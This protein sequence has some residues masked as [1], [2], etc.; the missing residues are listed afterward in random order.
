MSDA[1]APIEPKP[2]LGVGD[3]LSQTFQQYFSSFGFYFAIVFVPYLLAGLFSAYL[4]NVA[5]TGSID[6]LFSFLYFAAVLVPVIAYVGIQGVIVRAAISDRL[7]QG[8]QLQTAV[9]IAIRNILP[10]I[11]LGIGMTLLAGLGFLLLIVPG[12]Y[13]LA[14]FYLYVPSIMFERS[15][16]SGLAR[17]MEMTKGYRWPIVGIILIMLVLSWVITMIGSLLIFS[18]VSETLLNNAMFGQ[19]WWV[20]VL[21]AALQALVLPLSMIATAQVFVRLRNIKFGG[22]EEDLLRIFE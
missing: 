17:S 6:V 2:S 18:L 8:F 16:F 13:I 21:D 12:L 22:A 7:G 19:A 9:K 5:I 4:T 15:G 1:D 14:M 3:I 11:I 20:S 10:I